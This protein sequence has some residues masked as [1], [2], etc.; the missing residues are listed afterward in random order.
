MSAGKKMLL[1]A[2]ELS[3]MTGLSIQ[4][5]AH[6]RCQGKG[7]GYKKIGRM[8]RYPISDVE[9]WLDTYPTIKRS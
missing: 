2:E 5:F 6:W 9:E 4:T 7:P 3:E 8:I 1:S